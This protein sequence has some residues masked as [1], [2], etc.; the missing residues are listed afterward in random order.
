MHVPLREGDDDAIIPQQILDPETDVTADQ[1]ELSFTRSPA[2]EKQIENQC[3]V[4]EILEYD[5]GRGLQQYV[6]LLVRRQVQ[7]LY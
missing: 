4:P 7:Q 3:V 1:A 6:L 2:P 5:D